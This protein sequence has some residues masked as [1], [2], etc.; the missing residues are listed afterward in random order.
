MPRVF[1]AYT[2]TRAL[3]RKIPRTLPWSIP[4]STGVEN[5]LVEAVTPARDDRCCVAEPQASP[6]DPLERFHRRRELWTRLL[7]FLGSLSEDEISALIDHLNK[8]LN[9]R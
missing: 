9:K 2:H 3:A 8:G 7:F 4:L 6:A 5:V 1:E